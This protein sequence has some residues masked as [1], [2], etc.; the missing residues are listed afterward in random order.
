MAN[1]ITIAAVRTR[2]H[3]CETSSATT[4]LLS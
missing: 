1:Y 2:C 3:L 4:S